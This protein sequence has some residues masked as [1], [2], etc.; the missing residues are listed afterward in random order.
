MATRGTL[1][2]IPRQRHM[3]SCGCVGVAHAASQFHRVPQQSGHRFLHQHKRQNEAKVVD[4]VMETTTT[5]DHN[6][7]NN[8]NSLGLGASPTL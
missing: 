5:N 4:T 2:A 3:G 7:N 6:N 1:Y 8:N